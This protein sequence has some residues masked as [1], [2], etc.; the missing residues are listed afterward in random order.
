MKTLKNKK[1]KSVYAAYVEELRRW[2][3]MD[4]LLEYH[5]KLESGIGIMLPEDDIPYIVQVVAEF[6]EGCEG[7]PE[8]SNDPYE[9]WV[10]LPE[11]LIDNGL[12]PQKYL[13]VQVVDKGREIV[14]LHI[15]TINQAWRLYRTKH[16]QRVPRIMRQDDDDEDEQLGGSKKRQVLFGHHVTAVLRWM[17][18]DHWDFNEAKKALSKL[19]V[20][21]ADPTIRIQLR[22]GKTGERGEPAPLKD[23]DI[24]ILYEALND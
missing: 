3:T 2:V 17:G 9:E 5:R 14:G 18:T 6:L 16:P 1:A 10:G 8:R 4:E 24:N 22:A 12:N 23:E 11:F 19:R 7:R 20:Y 13:K 15:D 21:P